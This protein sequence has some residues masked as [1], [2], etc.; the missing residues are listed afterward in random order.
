MIAVTT[1][2]GILRVVVEVSIPS[3]AGGQ[4]SEARIAKLIEMIQRTVE[5]AEMVDAA[6]FDIRKAM[7]VDRNARNHQA[8]A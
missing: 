6:A 1:I 4:W 5:A 7:Y 8:R 3:A 2:D